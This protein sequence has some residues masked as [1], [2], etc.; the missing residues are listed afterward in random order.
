MPTKQDLI[1]A[2]DAAIRGATS[3]A[4]VTRGILADALTAALNFTDQQLDALFDIVGGV[5]TL[6][7]EFIPLFVDSDRP[8]LAEEIDYYLTTSE[9][10]AAIR[11]IVSNGTPPIAQAGGDATITLPTSSVTLVG[12]A[13]DSDGVI[14]AYAWAKASG[15]AGASLATP[16]AASC[17]V[18]GL[19]EGVYVFRFT[20]T[21]D[22]GN[23]SFD[24]VQVTV[25][26]AASG[27]NDVGLMHFVGGA[28][29]FVEGPSGTW[30]AANGSQGVLDLYARAGEAFRVEWDMSSDLSNN[31]GVVVGGGATDA[32]ESY[33]GYAFREYLNPPSGPNYVST[34]TASAN[35]KTA[36]ASDRRALWRALG[37]DVINY[38]VRHPGGAF[39]N[40]FTYTGIPGEVHFKVEMAS[41]AGK[42][43]NPE[44]LV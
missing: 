26:A 2:N 16:A 25:N 8:E 30:S 17:V 4:K 43:I 21:D 22:D 44:K 3:G 5:R 33:N 7:R 39:V 32:V 42:F 14:S 11:A 15:P 10:Q 29:S 41:G 1:T 9:G 37:S 12:S 35:A 28:S 27:G 36:Q 19:V 34:G 31:G 40:L 13:S 20:A 23:Q 6:K 38:D 18:S 24:D